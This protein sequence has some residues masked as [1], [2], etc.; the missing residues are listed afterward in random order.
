MWRPHLLKTASYMFAD[1]TFTG[2]ISRW[3][4]CTLRES[5]FMFHNAPFRGDLSRW[6]L[7]KLTTDNRYRMFTT[8]FDGV[9]PRM[10]TTFQE[11]RELYR[12]V[13]GG[14]KGLTAYLESH[15]FNPMH[16]DIAMHSKRC[17]N[18][19]AP[20]DWAW[21]QQIK[22]A[23]QALGLDEDALSAYALDE[24]ARRQAD[25]M[26]PL[27]GMDFSAIFIT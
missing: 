19:I 17:P 8:G 10:G 27:A 11:H 24:H 21:A 3:C 1:S 4:P 7:P 18:G 6:H 22:A 5:H 25:T 13:H 20:D 26:T 9:L 16:V 2:D 12:S 15:P 14:T 23:G